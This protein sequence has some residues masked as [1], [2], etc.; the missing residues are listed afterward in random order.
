MY[1]IA[2]VAY[3]LAIVMYI[4]AI[5]NWQ[6]AWYTMRIILETRKEKVSMPIEMDGETYLA[7]T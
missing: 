1:T 7:T 6:Y 4:L 2:I 3:V 5:V